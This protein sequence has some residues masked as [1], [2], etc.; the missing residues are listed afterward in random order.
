MTE[1]AKSWVQ[2]TV[3][4]VVGLSEVTLGVRVTS[5]ASWETFGVELLLLH[6]ERSRL[7]TLG[8]QV[9]LPPGNPNGELSGDLEENPGW[10]DV[11]L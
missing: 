9:G 2:A 3:S 8:H 7:R 1:K 6:I 10:R 4:S 5:W 11:S